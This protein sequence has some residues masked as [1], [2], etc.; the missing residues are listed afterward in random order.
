MV[1]VVRGHE[2]VKKNSL[3]EQRR[4]FYVP[5]NLSRLQ[6][7]PSEPNEEVSL[8]PNILLNLWANELLPKITKGEAKAMPIKRSQRVDLSVQGGEHI[9]S[10]DG[11]FMK[12]ITTPPA[13]PAKRGRPRKVVQETLD[14]LHQCQSSPRRIRR[15][16]RGQVVVMTLKLM[17]KRKKR[18]TVSC[19]RLGADASTR[20]DQ[21]FVKVRISRSRGAS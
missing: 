4:R 9:D 3:Y 16:G 15:R 19:R 8:S 12:A 20:G 10:R 1:R 21:V 2:M 11:E 7:G 5:L 13:P 17:M 18:N 6:Q 14:Q